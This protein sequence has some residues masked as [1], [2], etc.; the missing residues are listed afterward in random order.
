MKTISHH[1]QSMC[2]EAKE[3]QE[4]WIP[5]EGDSFLLH[6]SRCKPRSCTR[7]SLCETCLEMC[8]R[9]TLAGHHDEKV[10]FFN[11]M[12]CNKNGG[13]SLND[14]R[15]SLFVPTGGELS[16][17][18]LNFRH[19]LPTYQNE[20]TWVPSQNR[21]QELVVQKKGGKQKEVHHLMN[22]FANYYNSLS[23]KEVTSLDEV[24]LGYAMKEV[25]DKVWN[26]E[27]W[28]MIS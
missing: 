25:Y 9:F 18:S 2:F 11:P 6:A 12:L 23:M 27:S 3:L 21:L 17:L 15:A 26:G 4:N 24:W 5:Q 22:G 20:T 14:T 1:Y 7:F 13:M 10:F 16:N 28:E 19:H 8:N